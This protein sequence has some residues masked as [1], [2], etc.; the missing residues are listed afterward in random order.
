M[1]PWS[2]LRTPL[3]AEMALGSLKIIQKQVAAPRVPVDVLSEIHLY[4]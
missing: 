1:G 2:F 3:L 4:K